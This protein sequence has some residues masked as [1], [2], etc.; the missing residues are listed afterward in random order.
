MNAPILSAGLSLAA[1]LAFG[2]DTKMMPVLERNGAAYV[3][4]SALTGGAQIAVKSMPGQEQ[5]VVC[6]AD[7][8]ALVKATIREGGKM[9]LAVKEVAAALGAKAEWSD[10]RKQVSFQFTQS[11]TPSAASIALVGQLAP[12][13]RLAKL[14]GTPVEFADFLGKRVLI[15]SWASW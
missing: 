4:A 9:L 2:G 6:H 5:M 12:N 1:A 11:G 13:F 14:D 8:C 15:N 7:R 3:S 10:D